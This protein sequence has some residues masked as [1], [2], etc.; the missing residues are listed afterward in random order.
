MQQLVDAGLMSKSQAWAASQDENYDWWND[1]QPPYMPDENK[2]ECGADAL[3]SLNHSH[4]C[5]KAGENK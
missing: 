5:P 3:G 1:V 4:W 2:C